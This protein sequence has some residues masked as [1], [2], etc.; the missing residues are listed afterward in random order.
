MLTYLLRVF[1]GFILF[2]LA[3][4]ILRMFM[5]KPPARSE[6]RFKPPSPPRREPRIR[7]DRN[8]IIDGKFDDI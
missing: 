6:G 7:I 3:R 8:N 1:L 5:F 4:E 2:Q